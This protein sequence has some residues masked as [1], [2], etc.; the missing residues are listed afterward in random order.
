[1]VEKGKVTIEI[2]KKLCKGCGIC[3]GL[4]PKNVLEIDGSGKANAAHLDNCIGCQLCELRCPDFA[5]RVG[6]E[7]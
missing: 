2:N 6:R 3:V 7:A 5:I 1:M 4:C